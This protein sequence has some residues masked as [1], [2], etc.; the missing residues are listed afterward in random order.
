MDVFFPFIHDKSKK[1][2]PEAQP[3]YVE[4][5]EMPREKEPEKDEGA[6]ESLIIVQL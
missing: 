6:A 5:Y 2:E 3:L 1:K 4:V